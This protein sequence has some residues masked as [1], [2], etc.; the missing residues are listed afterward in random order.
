[1]AARVTGREPPITKPKKRGPA[2]AIVAGEQISSRSFRVSSALVDCAG[3]G[4]SSALSFPM[5]S[6]E[7]A[8]PLLSSPSMYVM[9][10]PAAFS[11]SFLIAFSLEAVS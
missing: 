7:G 5:A 3:N 4:S 11:K 1:L 9:A 10:R 8:T 2:M 6:A